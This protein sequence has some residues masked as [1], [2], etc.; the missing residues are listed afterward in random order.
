MPKQ[1]KKS[2]PSSAEK[3]A[4]LREDEEAAM[5]PQNPGPMDKEYSDEATEA[6]ERDM[7]AS[8]Q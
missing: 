8:W 5:A 1:Q 2:S 3:E 4:E 7:I 6:E